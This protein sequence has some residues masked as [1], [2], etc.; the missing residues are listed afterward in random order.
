VAVPILF[1]PV[2]AVL[3]DRLTWFT[4]FL[5]CLFTLAI[6]RDMFAGGAQH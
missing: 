5:Q 6:W 4:I 3:L 2:F 1:G